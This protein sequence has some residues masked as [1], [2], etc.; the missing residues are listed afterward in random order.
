MRPLV[1]NRYRVILDSV[2]TSIVV[3][4][5]SRLVAETT[6]VF[7]FRCHPDDLVVKYLSTVS[8]VAKERRSA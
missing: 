7:H 3:E 5:D 1:V 2:E 4:A 8:V 6:G